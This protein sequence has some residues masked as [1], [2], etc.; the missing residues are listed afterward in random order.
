MR[1]PVRKILSPIVAL[2]VLLGLWQAS[3]LIWTFPAYFYTPTEIGSAWVASLDAN[4]WQATWDT[5]FRAG[6]GF[7]IGTI[8]ALPI[9]AIT[10]RLRRVENT[11]E[12]Y[13]GFFY[14]LPKISLLPV[15][16]VWLG[17]TD[18]ARI[19][20][21]A[22]S[23]FFPVYV[24]MNAGVKG[25]NPDYLKVASN[26]GAG[27]WTTFRDV[28]VPAAAP[29]AMAGLRVGLAI[30]L[31]VTF[32]TEVVGQSPNGLGR[33]IQDG[34]IAVAYTEMYAG[35]IMFALIGLAIDL[36]LRLLTRNSRTLWGEAELA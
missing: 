9:G 5:L 21:I 32:A 31:I 2:F 4:M 30:S 27:R 20:M 14:A 16:V 13:I 3:S 26:L 35:I 12:P 33:I 8:L 23:V 1:F 11:V 29:M 22:I 25:I 18:T 19:T 6:V 17:Y 28:L 34:F 15:L 36:A 10:A 7:L 24:Y